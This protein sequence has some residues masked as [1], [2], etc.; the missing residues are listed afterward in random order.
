MP[1]ATT[2]R[3][4][5][6]EGQGGEEGAEFEWAAGGYRTPHPLE[7]ARTCGSGETHAKIEKSDA[8]APN[9][10]GARTAFAARK[11]GKMRAVRPQT[12]D[13]ADLVGEII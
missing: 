6:G 12:G 11:A 13:E 4:G 1:A 5:E 8:S 9:C 2:R 10:A 3:G 7:R